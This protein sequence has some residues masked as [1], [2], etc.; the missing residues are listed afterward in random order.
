[1]AIV[2][3]HAQEIQRVIYVYDTNL[4]VSKSEQKDISKVTEL[5]VADL[6]IFGVRVS[7]EGALLIKRAEIIVAGEFADR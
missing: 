5:K 7:F 1:V 2:L 4:A 6:C 3:L